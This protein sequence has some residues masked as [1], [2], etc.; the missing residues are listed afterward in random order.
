MW[1][2]NVLGNQV[3]IFGNSSI[4]WPFY[5]KITTV[6]QGRLPTGE[7]LPISLRQEIFREYE[8]TEI[9]VDLQAAQELLEEQLLKRLEAL[10]GEGGEVRATNTRA[11][12][13]GTLF[14]VTMES[15]CLEEIGREVPGQTSM[16]Q[17]GESGT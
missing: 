5:D 15:E 12:V 10:V 13:D 3:E 16:P 6:R 7:A 9:S 14:K 4:S 17:Q 1:S 2:V 8:V 11:W